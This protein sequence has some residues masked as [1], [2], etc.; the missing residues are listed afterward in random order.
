MKKS[1]ILLVFLLGFFLVGFYFAK[2][3]QKNPTIENIKS[4]EIA[5]QNIKIDLALTAEERFRGLSGR[6]SLKENEGLLFVFERE[7]AHSF[8]MKDMK[9]PIDIIWINKEMKVVFVKEKALP[10]SYPESFSS[11]KDAKY[12][13]EVSSGF[14]EKNNLKV[15]DTVLFDF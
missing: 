13:L 5:G 14:S 2:S 11:E 1:L 4:V 7:G 9:F 3:P 15:G 12:V 6:E 8:W 10:E